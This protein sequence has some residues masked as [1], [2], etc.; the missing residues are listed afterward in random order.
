ME[1]LLALCI[2][3]GLSAACGF[4][5]FIPLFGLSLAAHSGHLSLAS[6]FQWLGSTPAAVALGFATA[7]EIAAFYVPWLDHFLDVVASPAAV[8][9]GIMVTASVMTDM[10]PLLR[11]SLAIIAGGGL[12][13]AVQASTVTA[14]LASGLATGG[15]GNPLIATIELGASLASTLLALILPIGAILVLVGS[16][17]MVGVAA[18]R[19]HT[20]QGRAT[21]QLPGS[22]T[23]A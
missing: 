19:R 21:T 3:L 9:A 2:G 7:L 14:R 5:V 16:V 20:A 6:D 10:S 13:A 12:S 23:S 1:T 17:G 8:V 15:L 22:P 11:W 18:H 4:R